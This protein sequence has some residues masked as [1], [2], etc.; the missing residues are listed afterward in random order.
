[1]LNVER[2]CIS[3]CFSATN[4]LA[5]SIR[6]LDRGRPAGAAEAG[7]L[8]RR[9]KR[10]SSSASMAAICVVVNMRFMAHVHVYI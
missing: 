8:G 5:R 2:Y 7:L 3:M 6:M 9:N 4:N 1:M 10:R